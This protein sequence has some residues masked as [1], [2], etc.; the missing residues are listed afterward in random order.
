MISEKIVVIDDDARVI[1]SIRFI[2]PE[3]EIIEFHNG[4]DA[5]TYLKKPNAIN[6]VLL[7]VM[8][9]GMDGMSVLQEIKKIPKDIVVIMM[10]AYGS[11]NVAVQALR[12]HADDFIEKPF[13]VRE[14]QEKIKLKLKE[15]SHFHK[16]E[17]N[18]VDRVDRIK[19]FIE[20][21]YSNVSL[22][23]IASELSLST[24]YVSRMF[25]GATG[26]NFR[27][28]KLKVKLDTAMS[29]LRTTSFTVEE[30]SDQLGYFNPESFM[31]IF[32]RKTNRTPSEYRKS[33]ARKK[34]IKNG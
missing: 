21:N 27:D 8:M 16:D 2:L 22:E 24:R 6:V 23:S 31:R 20:R 7:D 10:T 5:L 33:C 9:P 26:H 17:G 25:N 15:S 13:D 30:I 32:K 3:Y 34:K 1:K 14:L 11:M 29:L 12:N 19:R 4:P 28:Y 18:S